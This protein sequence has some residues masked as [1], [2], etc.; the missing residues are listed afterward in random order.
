MYDI[1]DTAV[2]SDSITD[3]NGNPADVTGMTV[4]VT[5]PDGTGVS[6][7]VTHGG[8]GQYSAQYTFTQPGRHLVTWSGTG[9]SDTTV[10]NCNPADPLTIVSIDDARLAV[11]NVPTIDN[12]D[13]RRMLTAVTALIE[14]VVG[15][16]VPR[17]FTE[18]VTS[19]ADASGRGMIVLSYTPVL[20]ITSIT[21]RALAQYLPDPSYYT[22]DGDSG[23]VTL[24]NWD[25]WF[26]PLTVT[27]R[28]GRAVIPANI[29]EAALEQFRLMWQL[30]RQGNRPQY[31]TAPDDET[32]QPSGFAL[33]RDVMA[34]L[35]PNRLVGGIA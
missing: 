8:T 18:V 13:M 21:A 23:L 15:P 1:G 7:S 22:L 12:E 2:L 9:Y 4:T 6:P 11:G 32:W 20:S 31:G 27:Y 28:A 30:T 19:R 34:L 24:S 14:D 29:Q 35:A 26:G 3:A 5:L 33:S 17:T 10:L 16:V 25:M